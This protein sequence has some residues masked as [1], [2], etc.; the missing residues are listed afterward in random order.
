MLFMTSRCSDEPE[1]TPVPDNCSE[2]SIQRES[3]FSV[4]LNTIG[5]KKSTFTRC[6]NAFADAL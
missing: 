3:R 2:S 4:L 6:A 5:D 1:N